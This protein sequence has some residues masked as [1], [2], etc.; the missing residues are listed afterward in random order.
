MFNNITA[1]CGSRNLPSKYSNIIS[2]IVQSV[3]DDGHD[4]VVGCA[5]GADKMVR[6]AAPNATVLYA[7]DYGHSKSSFARRSQAVVKTATIGMIGFTDKPCP[8]GIV[9]A[10]SWRSGKPT[11]GTWSSL[12]LAAGFD[13]TVTVYW[14]SDDDVDLPNWPSGQWTN[15]AK[16]GWCWSP[17]VQHSLFS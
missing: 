10:S 1:F 5:D 11:S 8:N 17:T 2:K 16:N 3:I 13:L 4:I 15:I 7:S 14:C 9:P 12:A 6:T